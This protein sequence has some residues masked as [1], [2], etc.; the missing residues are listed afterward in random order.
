MFV[1]SSRGS[2]SLKAPNKKEETPYL[3]ILTVDQL[4][5]KKEAFTLQP[6]PQVSNDQV[7]RVE[8]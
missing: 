3:D 4:K 2:A 8:L 7:S 6:P 1:I 5:C